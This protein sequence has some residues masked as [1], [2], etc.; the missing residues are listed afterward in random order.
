MKPPICA[1]C[2]NRF[3]LLEDQSGLV[4]FKKRQSDKDWEK[5]MQETG[6]VGHPP[7]A[8]WFCRHHYAKAKELE[9]LTVDKAMALIIEYYKTS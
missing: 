9:N 8:R 6:M 5:K 7:Y 1:V 3:D 4:Y 2:D